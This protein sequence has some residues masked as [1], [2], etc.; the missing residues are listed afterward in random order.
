MAEAALLGAMLRAGGYRVGSF[1]SPHL[2]DYRERIRIDGEMVSEASLVATA[3]LCGLLYAIVRWKDRRMAGV[4]LAGP[5]RI[6]AP[7]L[8]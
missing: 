2:V 4:K 6:F 1:T 7:V 3:M 5:F 8:K